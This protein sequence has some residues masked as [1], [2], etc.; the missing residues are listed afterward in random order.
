MK[1]LLS[2]LLALVFIVSIPVSVSALSLSDGYTALKNQFK[3]GE[4]PKAEG[5]SIDYR[6]FSPVKGS[7]NTTKYPLVI[8]LH[9]NKNGT[10]D[11]KQL[12]DIINWSSSELQSRFHA[13]GAFIFAPRCREE[14]GF[15]WDDEEMLIPLKAAIDSFIEK[16]KGNID[17]SRIYISGFS[18]GGMMALKV[19]SEYP[20]MFAAAF[21]YCPATYL[22]KSMARKFKE[23]PVWLTSSN[24][25]PSVD[26][27]YLTLNNWKSITDTSK[28]KAECRLSTLGEVCYPDG[29][30]ADSHH[31]SWFAVRYD[32]FS[33]KGGNYPNMTTV[34][35][36][37]KSVT[38]TY[39]NGM[40]S[41]LSAHTSDYGDNNSDDSGV[42]GFFAFIR[43]SFNR[44][45][46][47]VKNVILSLF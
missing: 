5:Y 24:L 23:V 3:F 4:G 32:M 20:E 40:I 6:Y 34:D 7:G 15:N 22:T 45:V 18:M 16:N 27:E 2:L 10:Y 19:L 41:W 25:D 29:S 14:S 9:G 17:L 11:G 42:S 33:S 44:F 47:A 43:E 26:Y 21:P 1:K 38:L 30:K 13:K 37:G 8:W 46:A 35:G 31:Y 36:N 28:V 12:N 39:P